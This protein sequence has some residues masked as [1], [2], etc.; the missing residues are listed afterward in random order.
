MKGKIGIEEKA[1]FVCVLGVI[2]FSITLSSLSE[3]DF[4]P[5][6]ALAIAISA[7]CVFWRCIVSPSGSQRREGGERRIIIEH[8]IVYH[9]G[10]QS[11]PPEI[12]TRELDRPGVK[13]LG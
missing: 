12:V 9:D 2:I 13:R 6:A 1:F 8:R 4:R 11:L 5:L 7:A 10:T 3:N